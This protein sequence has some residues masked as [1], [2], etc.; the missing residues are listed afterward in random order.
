MQL[1]IRKGAGLSLDEVLAALGRWLGWLG[2]LGGLILRRRPRDGLG[3]YAHFPSQQ[4][5]LKDLA[6]TSADLPAIES[7]GYARDSTRRQR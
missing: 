5:W 2:S 3:R 7:G 6:L 1:H 4:A